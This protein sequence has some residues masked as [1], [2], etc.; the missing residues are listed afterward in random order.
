VSDRD[1]RFADVIPA[2]VPLFLHECVCE[3]RVASFGVAIIRSFF[4]FLFTVPAVP[5]RPQ[6]STVDHDH[7]AA[8][9][10]MGG[11]RAHVY[12]FS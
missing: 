2:P 11:T 4:F 7:D 12:N 5:A 9:A 6:L 1:T 10:G 3:C 8:R